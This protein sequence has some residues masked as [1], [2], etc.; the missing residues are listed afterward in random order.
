MSLIWATRGRSWG[1][2]FLLDGGYADPLA[3]YEEASAGVEGDVTACLRVGDVVAL[4]FP[5]PLGRKDTSGRVIP[6][7]FVVMAPLAEQIKSV[8]D[9][10]EKVWPLVADA[11]ARVWDSEQPPAKM[12]SGATTADRA[13]EPRR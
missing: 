3:A 6:H 7:D 11:Y 8:D 4:R 12:G 9:G 5:D 13:T 2:R 10:L 1:F